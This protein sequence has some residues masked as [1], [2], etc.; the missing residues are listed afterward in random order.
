MRLC[1]TRMFFCACTC[2]HDHA[3][4][5]TL[6]TMAHEKT[7]G[8]PSAHWTCSLDQLHHSRDRLEQSQQE[9]MHWH[10]ERTV[11]HWP[12]PVQKGVFSINVPTVDQ[13]TQLRNRV[14]SHRIRR[15][16]VMAPRKWRFC[17]LS[18]LSRCSGWLMRA[19]KPE[20]DD[21]RSVNS[22]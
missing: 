5:M 13:R 20:C 16:T 22:I 4:Y 14:C 18:A 21:L 7:T 11:P 10:I 2:L 12:H 17:S 1:M 9:A 15:V 6:L 3:H 8:T 19:V